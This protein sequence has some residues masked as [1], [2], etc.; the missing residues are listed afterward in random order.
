MYMSKSKPRVSVEY[1]PENRRI[2]KLELLKNKKTL[3]SW[4]RDMADKLL[5][6]AGYELDEDAE[7]KT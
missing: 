7:I 5:K 3:S 1:D 6:D 2:L 4:F